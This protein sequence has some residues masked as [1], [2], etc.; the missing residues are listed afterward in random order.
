MNSKC[1]FSVSI[2]LF[3]LLRSKILNNHIV[4][5]SKMFTQMFVPVADR[6]FKLF[7]K[8]LITEN[9]IRSMSNELI[10]YKLS[11]RQTFSKHRKRN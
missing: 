3:R 11:H 1:K 7:Y 4:N 8:A 9:L 2:L 5:I 10:S 6:I